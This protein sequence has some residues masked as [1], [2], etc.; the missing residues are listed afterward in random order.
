M[1]R[2]LLQQALNALKEWDVLIKFQYSGSSE[3]MTAMQ[4]AA[5]HTEDVIAAIEQELAKLKE[6]NT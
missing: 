6:K 3:A 5:W 4:Y 1:S 2:E